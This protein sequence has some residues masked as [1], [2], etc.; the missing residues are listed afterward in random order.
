MDELKSELETAAASI[1]E[2][3]AHH[4]AGTTWCRRTVL[5]CTANTVV[6][7]VASDHPANAQVEKEM[8]GLKALLYGKFKGSINL[9][10]D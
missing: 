1:K 8:A 10:D 7:P 9:E 6:P 3:R 2:A 5:F 4:T